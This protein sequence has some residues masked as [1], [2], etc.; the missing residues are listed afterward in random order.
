MLPEND[1]RRGVWVHA[2]LDNDHDGF[3]RR[4]QFR[5]FTDFFA[6]FQKQNGRWR[7]VTLVRGE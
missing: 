7:L 6:L 3:V 4:S 2:N 1:N 5:A